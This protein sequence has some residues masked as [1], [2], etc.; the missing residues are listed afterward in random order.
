[1]VRREL[2]SLVASLCKATLSG[3]LLLGCIRLAYG[4]FALLTGAMAYLGVGT[5]GAI[6]LLIAEA[7][8]GTGSSPRAREH[9][10]RWL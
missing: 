1:M 5:D 9:G 8:S 2:A 6:A 7:V 3:S 10:I 4:S